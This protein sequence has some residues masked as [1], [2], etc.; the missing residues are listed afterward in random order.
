MTAQSSDAVSDSPGRRQP[1]MAERDFTPLDAT[2]HTFPR[3]KPDECGLPAP[4]GATGFGGGGF[5]VLRFDATPGSVT[6]TRSF[7]RSTLTDWRL[8][9]LVDDATTV[10]AELVANAVTHAL[11]PPVPV[12]P[13]AARSETTAWIALVRMDHSVVCAVADPSP[14][15]PA[16]TEPEPFAESGRGLH[17]VAELSDTWGHIRPESA[18]GKTVWARLSSVR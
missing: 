12:R 8:P 6:R 4:L 16:L 1:A 18:A 15:L 14:A 7:L 17:I 13:F 5:A 11:Q 10:A 9:E 2:L 3:P